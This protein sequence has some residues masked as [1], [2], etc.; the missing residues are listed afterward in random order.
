MDE[1]LYFY[2]TT[3]CKTCQPLKLLFKTKFQ[4]QKTQV[5]KT[6]AKTI[7]RHDLKIKN[8]LNKTIQIC[9]LHDIMNLIL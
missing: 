4:K 5:A 2:V 6:R 9:N 8:I 7:T 1:Y 3:L